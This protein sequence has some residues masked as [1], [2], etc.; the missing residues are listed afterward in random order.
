MPLKSAP[1]K[2]RVARRYAQWPPATLDRRDCF[3]MGNQAQRA[4]K[5]P[6]APNLKENSILSQKRTPIDSS[7][8]AIPVSLSLSIPPSLR[9]PSSQIPNL[10]RDD[11][12]LIR[13]NYASCNSCLHALRSV[14]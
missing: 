12:C 1:L 7:L 14:N 2:L 8:F 10:S 9:T 6:F 4:K 11:W 3:V 5:A 13:K